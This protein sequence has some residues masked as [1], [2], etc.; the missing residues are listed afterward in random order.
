MNILVDTHYLIWI[1]NNPDK[2]NTKIKKL[3]QSDTNNIYAS[4]INFWEISLKSTLGKISLKNISLEKVYKSTM[5]SNITILNLTPQEAISFYKL[6]LTKHQD[7]F[8]RM[9][10]WQAIYNNY[11]FL[12]EDKY[13]KNNYTK[14]GL[15]LISY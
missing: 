1:L 12:T 9:L 5:E 4:S 15:K 2:I 13:I 14:F 8:D 11:F 7:P 10:I 6:P 3:L